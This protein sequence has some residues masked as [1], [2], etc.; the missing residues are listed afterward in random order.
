ME[1]S[2]LD[3]VFYEE[4]TAK[5]SPSSIKLE[6][7]GPVSSASC[8]LTETTSLLMISSLLQPLS[9]SDLVSQQIINDFFGRQAYQPKIY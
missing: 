1:D 6:L 7:L 2:P 3:V 5:L 9:L 8:L 4:H